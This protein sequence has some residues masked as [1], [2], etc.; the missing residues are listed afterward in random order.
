LSVSTYVYGIPRARKAARARR[1]LL[2]ALAAVAGHVL[3]LSVRVGVQLPGL[4][5]AAA[6]CY[7]LWLAWPPLGFVAVGTFLLLVDRRAASGPAEP[8][9]VAR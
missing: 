6:I 5:G 7:G 8:G 1:R 4:A 3:R 2:P 9:G